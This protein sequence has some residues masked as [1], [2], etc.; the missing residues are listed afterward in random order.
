VSQTTCREFTA[1]SNPAE[2]GVRE[3]LCSSLRGTWTHGPCPSD[4]VVATCTKPDGTATLALSCYDRPG[5]PPTASMLTCQ[6]ACRDDGVF[7]K[8]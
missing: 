5:V 4:N 7:E 3:S 6:T 2:W 1:V 8:K